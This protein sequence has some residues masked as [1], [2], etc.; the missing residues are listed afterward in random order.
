MCYVQTIVGEQV[1]AERFQRLQQQGAL[2]G[3]LTSRE[4]VAHAP[5]DKGARVKKNVTGVFR[6]GDEKLTVDKVVH[7]SPAVQVKI[8]NRGRA[9][10]VDE[11]QKTLRDPLPSRQYH[12]QAARRRTVTAEVIG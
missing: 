2:A 6:F 9:S 1:G 3:A 11:C 7:A 5:N 4:R 10:S 12:F 8:T